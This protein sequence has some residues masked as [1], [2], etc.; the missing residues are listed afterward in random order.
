[1]FHRITVSGS[2]GLI[3]KELI[4]QLDNDNYFTEVH[5]LVRLQSIKT[6]QKVKEKVID[7]NTV[8]ELPEADVLVICLGT[9]RKKAGSKEGFRKVDYGYVIHLARLAEKFGYKKIIVI[10]SMGA[11][12]SSKNFYLRVKG[13]MEDIIRT[14]NVGAKI[15]IRPS[16]LLGQRSEFRLMEKMAAWVL[17]GMSPMLKGSFLKYRPVWDYTVANEII[18]QIKSDNEG[19]L[20]VEP[21]DMHKRTY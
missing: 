13:E 21:E 8:R 5:S 11:N 1:M 18:H 10:S 20:V 12:A 4:S 9:T 2:T 16:L 3:G 15:V 14:I 7:Y 6:Y 17:K 19:F